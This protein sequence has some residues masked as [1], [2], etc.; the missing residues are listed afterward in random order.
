LSGGD[1]ARQVS[2][3]GDAFT[4][5]GPSH[6]AQRKN[7]FYSD[8]MRVLSSRR[9]DSDFSLDDVRDSTPIRR[10]SN[11]ADPLGM[12]P[13]KTEWHLGKVASFVPP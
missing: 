11:L 3:E 8:R 12:R 1:F 10:K 7:I 2:E 6:V 5:R 9:D 13:P 4:V